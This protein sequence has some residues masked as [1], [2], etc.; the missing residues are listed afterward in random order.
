MKVDHWAITCGAVVPWLLGGIIVSSSVVVTLTV[1][2]LRW[3]NSILFSLRAQCL[4]VTF[5]RIVVVG[6]ILTKQYWIR[7]SGIFEAQS[8]G[9]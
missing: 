3:A 1:A 2:V 8:V 6:V 9:L 5:I 7:A 4:R